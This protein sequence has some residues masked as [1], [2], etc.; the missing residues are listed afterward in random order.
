MNILQIIN[1]LHYPTTLSTGTSGSVRYHPR[2]TIRQFSPG[3]LLVIICALFAVSFSAEIQK[4]I[5]V[6]NH[7][8]ILVHWIRSGIDSAVV[9]NVDAH[10]DCA[11]IPSE[12]TS[13]L[14]E[15]LKA[16]DMDAIGHANSAADG[17][18]FS[19]SD[20]ISAA[21]ALGTARKVIWIAPT[22]RAPSLV[23]AHI[24]LSTGTLDSLPQ[25]GTTPVLLTVDAD[26][27]PPFASRLCISQVEAIRRVAKALR[28]VSWNIVHTSVAFS[29]DGGYLPLTLRW[30]GN[31]LKESLEGKD[32]SRAEAPWSLLYRV[33]DWR[34]G[35]PPGEI[36]RKVRQLVKKH[37]DN[38]WLRVYLADALFR[39]KDVPGALREGKI[40]ARLDPGCCRILPEI[41]RQLADAGQV[42]EAERFLVAAPA[43]INVAAELALAQALERVGQTARAIDHLSRIRGVQANYSAEL[44]M[45]YGYER[46]GDKNAARIHYLGAV[47]LLA[48]PVRE[49]PAFPDLGPATVAAERL[50]R[51]GG[52][53]KE[54]QALRRDPRLVSFFN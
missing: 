35:L 24:P 42:H 34:R 30:V 6:E 14:Q 50:L 33:E 38:P 44:L 16:G 54:A 49:M 5:L 8:D 20:Y 27:I 25:L 39:S 41:G 53:K 18:L 36:V 11:P 3:T 52:Y 28:G 45:G 48:A 21:G 4:V 37:P 23:R 26:F 17:G 47:S 9:V 13:K 51:A 1:L 2:D 32:P 46:L 19:I 43:M 12:N 22:R 15:F 29:V 40:A 31:A 10:D 7:S